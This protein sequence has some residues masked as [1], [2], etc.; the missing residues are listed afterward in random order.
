[1]RDG[2]QGTHLSAPKEQPPRNL[3]G[4]WTSDLELHSGERRA[5]VRRRDNFLRRKDRG[6]TDVGF[7]LRDRCRAVRSL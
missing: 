2:P 4:Q 1:M 5:S 7:G 6:G 3:S